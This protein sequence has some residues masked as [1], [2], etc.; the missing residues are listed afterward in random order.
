[1]EERY[2]EYEV[3]YFDECDRKDQ[4]CRGVT[5]ARY[6][7]DAISN[8]AEFYGEENISSLQVYPL[9]PSPV[10]EFS[11]A[12]NNFSLDYRKPNS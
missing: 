10:Y 9:N 7:K 6:I 3:K 1:M 4:I 5:S 11:Y 2:F 12:E 8:I